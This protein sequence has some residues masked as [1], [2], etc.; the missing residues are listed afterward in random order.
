MNVKDRERS[1]RSV[2][3]EGESLEEEEGRREERR[4]ERGG[5]EALSCRSTN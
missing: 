1:E 3:V 4:K 2:K 5:L